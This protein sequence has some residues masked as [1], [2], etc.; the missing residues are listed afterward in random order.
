MIYLKIIESETKFTGIQFEVLADHE[1]I[2]EMS[3]TVPDTPN[4]YDINTIAHGYH[5][6]V[7]YDGHHYGEKLGF[8]RYDGGCVDANMVG[9][10]VE[11]SI[12]VS[13]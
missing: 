4:G 3:C 6:S 10:N 13:C 12:R 2:A 7:S 8:Y 9:E 11:V 5:I 1:S